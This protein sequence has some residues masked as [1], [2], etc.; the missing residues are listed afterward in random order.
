VIPTRGREARL[1]FAL[2]SLAGQLDEERF[3]VVVVRDGD[4]SGPFARAPT[5]VRLRE[6]VRPGSAGPTAKRNLGWRS[7]AAPLVAFT[8]DDCRAAPGWLQHLLG[9]ADRPERFVQGRTVPDPDEAHLLHGLARSVAVEGPT[10]WFE[11]CNMAYPRALLERLGGFDEAFWFGGEDTDLAWRA[12]EAGAEP[13]FCERALSWHAVV[14]RSLPGALAEAARWSDLPAV[15]RRHPGLRDSLYRGHFWTP[16]HMG[17]T[18]AAAGALLAG[19]RAPA[20]A[21]IAAL[22]YLST[23]LNWR[24]PHP[25][26][27]ARGLATLPALAAVDA[28]EV[29]ARLPS[30]IRNRV[31][32]I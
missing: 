23:R 24:R 3:E 9:A 7:T 4:A 10:G 12:I 19:R 1:A 21:L 8:D 30:A 25:R 2:E 28:T 18:V 11:T 14:T 6:L 26:R 16:Q 20:L 31:A 15:V 5:G 29:A 22:P 17:V 13:V 32:V 27:L